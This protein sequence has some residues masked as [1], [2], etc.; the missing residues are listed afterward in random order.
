MAGKYQGPMSIRL[1]GWRAKAEEYVWLARKQMGMMLEQS[2]G[3]GWKQNTWTKEYK[4]FGVKVRTEQ[5]TDLIKVAFISAIFEPAKDCVG[6]VELVK[7]YF[8]EQFGVPWDDSTGY[9][10]E[11][12]DTTDI[13]PPEYTEGQ[14]VY[15]DT[16]YE[17]FQLILDAGT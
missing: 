8:D 7:K 15:E 6:V 3:A 4:A 2:R 9:L 13:D 17:Q 11:N 16:N 14:M 12:D 10:Q 5:I 1:M